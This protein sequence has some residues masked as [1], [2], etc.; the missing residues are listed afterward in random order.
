MNVLVTFEPR[1][2]LYVQFRDA[3]VA[4]TVELLKDELLVDLDEYANVLGI[5]A[6]RPG[7]LYVSLHKILAA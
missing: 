5:E 1:G 2:A 6:L 7:T 3:R 4:K